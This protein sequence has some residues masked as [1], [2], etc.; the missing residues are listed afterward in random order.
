MRAHTV[1]GTS[2]AAG[3][4]HPARG[5]GL[6]PEPSAWEEVAPKVTY[7]QIASRAY[8]IY[9]ARGGREGDELGDWLAAEHELKAMAMTV[10]LLIRRHRAG[11]SR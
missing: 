3:D 2:G 4:E 5:A 8:E 11:R 10:P 9:R 1:H 7:E 6:Q